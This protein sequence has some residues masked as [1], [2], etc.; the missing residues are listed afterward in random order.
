MRIVKK[1]FL[2]LI[3]LVFCY[4]VGFLSNCLVSNK[5]NFVL[6][7]ELLF[8]MKTLLYAFF[9]FMVFVILIAYNWYKGYWSKH[10]KKLMESSEKDKHITAGLEEAHFQSEKELK[11]NFKIIEFD[12]LKHSNIEGIPIKAELGKK[13]LQ[14]AL[15]K[16][17]H[18][19]II[20]T[21]GSGKTTTFINPSVQILS[22]S[23]NKPSMLLTDPKGELYSLHAD[24]LKKQGYDVK[25]IDLRNPY[26]SVRWNPLE[27]PYEQ[28]Q[29][30]LHLKDEV[31]ADEEKG[32][33][34][35]QNKEYYSLEEVT[36]ARQ[37]KE[38]EIYDEVYED[39]HD[40][41]SVLCPVM[42]K[43]EPI[44]ESGAKNFILAIVLAMLEDSE[45]P[46]L[47]MTKEKFNFYNI[48]KIA[49]NT[50]NDCEDLQKYFMKRS[51]I[52]KSVSLSKQVLDASDKTRGSYL[53]TIF[54]K[55]AMFSD[56][57]ICALTSGNEVDFGEIALRPTALFLQVPD[58]KETRHTLASMMILQAYKSLV[59][60]ANTFPDLSLPR[61]VYFLLDEFGNL[62]RVH[63]LEQMITVGRSRKIWLALVVQSYAQ[64]SK[65]YDEK[66]ADIIKSNCNIQIFIGTTDLKT[67]NDFSKLCGN[68]SI[69][70]RN[71]S[72][73]TG[74]GNDINSSSSV[75]E[76]PLIYPSELAQLNNANNMGNAVV[77]VFG[78]PPIMSKFTPSFRCHKYK[79]N[80]V[81]QELKDGKAFMEEK[82]F[83]NMLDRNAFYFKPKSKI[84]RESKN[85]KELL[86]NRVKTEI[87]EIPIDLIADQDKV[88]LYDMLEA[89]NYQGIIDMLN[90]FIVIDEE[91]YNGLRKH[92]ENLT[93]QFSEIMK[94]ENNVNEKSNKT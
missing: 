29:K 10:S 22:H 59:A 37:V 61:S 82:V 88:Y 35:F 5:F 63:K 45:N 53:S 24:E 47:G 94:L 77:N 42:N 58:E 70:Q 66:S 32:C 79:M 55:L 3:L 86:T 87:T 31:I 20:G 57:S 67:I 56:K 28:Y 8:E 14:I 76:R 25:I 12:E 84:M 78:F 23:K 7:F 41:I 64:L 26:C 18:T 68:Y 27:K 19:L 46:E 34:Y 39:L 52:S 2:W 72:F 44:W 17:A 75:K 83:Y 9:L 89:N 13:G 91:K 74:K 71:I 80:P 43:G 48:M 69:V 60:K 40:I 93:L 33:Y 36:S 21:T 51:P 6:N 85:Q 92:I 50:Q 65:V 15:S 4:G 16:P 1:L 11:T 38:Q 90:G 30:M 73:N 49:T 54:D 62:P 81:K